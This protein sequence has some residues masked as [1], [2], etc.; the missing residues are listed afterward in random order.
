MLDRYDLRIL[1]QLQERGDIGPVELSERVALSASQCSRRL[2][3][4][5]RAGYVVAVRGILDPARINI[6]VS[7]YVLLTMASHAPDAADAFR[8][9]VLEWDEVLDCQMLTGE[10]DMILKVATKDLQTFNSLLTQ[11]ILG[12]P[13]VATAQSSIVLETIKSTTN[14]PLQFAET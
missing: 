5:R 14:L 11:K 1:E 8:A 12:A 3:A 13:E 10:A 9:R 6:G 4:L 7:A 2:A